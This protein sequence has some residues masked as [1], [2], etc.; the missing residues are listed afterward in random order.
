M[1]LAAA[2]VL[3][4][5]LLLQS[6]RYT[7]MAPLVNEVF[8]PLVF[9]LVRMTAVFFLFLV[10]FQFYFLSTCTRLLF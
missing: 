10:T 2:V 4:W 9:L 5:G 3:A 8:E 1:V 6:F 7:G